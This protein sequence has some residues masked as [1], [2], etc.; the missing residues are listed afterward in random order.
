MKRGM[1]IL[2]S[3]VAAL[4]ACSD[5]RP[6]DVADCREKAKQAYKVSD[7]GLPHDRAAVGAVLKCMQDK[8]YSPVLTDACQPPFDPIAWACFN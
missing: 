1:L 3:L 7:L 2:I 8:G 6:R 4:S 5:N